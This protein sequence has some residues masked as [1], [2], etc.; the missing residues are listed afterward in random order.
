MAQTLFL[1]QVV[2]LRGLRRVHVEMAFNPPAVIV[3]AHRIDAADIVIGVIHTMPIQHRQ[4][5]VAVLPCLDRLVERAVRHHVTV[6]VGF[7]G[8][9]GRVGD[10]FAVLERRVLAVSLESAIEILKVHHA[11]P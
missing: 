1:D 7:A 10:E 6:A 5:V 8:E 4:R 11:P 9:S 3:L 2:D